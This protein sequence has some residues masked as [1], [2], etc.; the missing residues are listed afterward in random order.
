SHNSIRRLSAIVAK[1]PLIGAK[2]PDL[3]GT[4]KR[5]LDRLEKEPV[6]VSITDQRTKKPVDVKV[7]K[8]GL[9]FLIMRDLGDTND[10]PIFPLWFY[11]MDKGDYSLLKRFVESVTTHWAPEFP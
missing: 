2:M 1:D 9:Q 8:V 5:I 11:T 6:T 4:L 3:A 10:L 7:G